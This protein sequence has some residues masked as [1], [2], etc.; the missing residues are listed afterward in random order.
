M[1]IG[2]KAILHEFLGIEYEHIEKMPDFND[3]SM[4]KRKILS[5]RSH[6]WDIQPFLY[7]LNSHIH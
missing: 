5:V 7:K 2:K 6:R 4:N 1:D 3:Y